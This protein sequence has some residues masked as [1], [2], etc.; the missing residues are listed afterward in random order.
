[1]PPSIDVRSTGGRPLGRGT[2]TARPLISDRR[3][4]EPEPAVPFT[5]VSKGVSDERPEPAYEP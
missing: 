1:M 4:S 2:S 5:Q 3:V